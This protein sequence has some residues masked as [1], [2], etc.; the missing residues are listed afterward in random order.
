MIHSNRI[1]SFVLGSVISLGAV[2]GIALAGSS[3]EFA[4]MEV[5][6]RDLDLSRDVDVQRLYAR[7][8]QAST[9]VCGSVPITDPQFDAYLNCAEAALDRAV[10]LVKSPRL[11][12]LHSVSRSQHRWG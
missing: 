9:K 5:S 3:V 12:T 4:R 8:Q 11:E 7:L 1:R 6:Y 2:S 10:Q